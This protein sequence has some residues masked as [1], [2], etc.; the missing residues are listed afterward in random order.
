MKVVEASIGKLRE[1]LRAGEATSVGL[2]AA[3]LNR[4]ACYD[5][6]GMT[7]N[8]V[9]VLNP[10]MF[11]EARASDVRRARGESL[12]PLDGIPYTAKDSYKVKGLSVAAGSPAFAD[13]VAT[14]DAFAIARL[15]AAGA[16]L[17]G[18]TNMPPMANGGMQRGVYGRAESPYNENWL[19]AAF[20]SG[21]SNGSGTATAASF[22][23][24]GLGE[25]TWSSGRA[26]A[27]NNGLCAYTPSR[28]VISVRG[29]WPLVPTMDV[30][31]PHSRSMADML[32]LLDII[33]ADD[34][35]SRGDLWR[36]QTWMQIPKASDVRPP[37]YV[38]I[39]ETASLAGKR[40]GLPA[41]YINADAGAG[42]GDT[43]GIGG[44]T[45][46]R[47]ETRASMI[48]LC[49]QAR[50]A[51]EAAG[52]EVVV[53]DFPVVS[54]Y[55]ADRPDAPTIATRGLVSPDY[56]RREILDLS[57]WAWDDFLAAN[58]DPTLRRLADVDGT[59]IFPAP[60]GSL[61]DRYH[62]FDDPLAAYPAHRR[63]HPVAAFE[64]IPGLAEG[65]CGL[66][67]TRRIDMEDWMDRLELDAVIFPAVADIGPADADVNPASADLAWR[68]G[69]WV[70][71]G[72]LAIRHLGI[73]TVTVPMG[74]LADIGMPAGL[75][76][77]GR[78][79]DDTALIACAAAFERTGAYRTAPPRT[80]ELADL[81]DAAG[82]HPPDAADLR[83]AATITSGGDG[84]Q[85]LS[86]EAYSAAPLLWLTVNGRPIAFRQED[87]RASASLDI[88]EN[89]HVHSEWRAP[90]GHIVIAR[91]QG[92]AA[93]AIV[94]GTA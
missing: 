6:H 37:S 58:A 89:S 52:A 85:R 53:T 62:G 32:E 14:D 88:D 82:A 78:A 23:A 33:V 17:I 39:A 9:P 2:V 92:A 30:V 42:T 61:P 1:A 3:Y 10:D 54:N 48:A 21:S 35:E 76:F 50:T 46:R 84:R 16:V 49:A 29:N 87:G 59:R 4:I 90:Y 67:E 74:M 81:P 83:L 56:L 34:P 86:I 40:F 19:T 26:P 20:G 43:P 66:E 69:T 68:N 11:S 55:E 70:A 25:E 77:A 45:G 93:Y 75:T 73:P 63:D 44:P 31:V 51:I 24:F 36:S 27:A 18:L 57:A 7:L 91:S 13:L 28:G 80:P 22:A 94:G 64:D 12:G 60:E 15:R 8:A 72:N 71:N 5:R 41:M 38:A 47:I 79:F 65:F